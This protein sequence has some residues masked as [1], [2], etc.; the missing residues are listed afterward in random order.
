L[1][2]KQL[3]RCMSYCSF[4]ECRPPSSSN[5]SCVISQFYRIFMKA[6]T[7]FH[8][9]FPHPLAPSRK[10]RGDFLEPLKMSKL[11]GASEG[12]GRNAQLPGNGLK[13]RRPAGISYRQALEHRAIPIPNQ[14]AI[15][16][17]SSSVPQRTKLYAFGA[18]ILAALISSL[19]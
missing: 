3:S 15:C 18:S 4:S 8:G 9:A 19:I 7:W 11:Q 10:G 16:V 6:M 14:G 13:I 17:G 2:R 12:G 1:A 5:I